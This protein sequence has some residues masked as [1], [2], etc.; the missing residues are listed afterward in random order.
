MSRGQDTFLS[1]IS[2]GRRTALIFLLV[3]GL[4]RGVGVFAAE[5]DSG[6]PGV[7]KYA[8]TYGENRAKAENTETARGQTGEKKKDQAVSVHREGRA[9]DSELRRRLQQR[10]RELKQL[11]DENRHLQERVTNV[12]FAP[13]II[14]PSPNETGKMTDDRRGNR[15]P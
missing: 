13:D 1:M 14:L 4:T 11:R 5:E 9:Q 15:K 7:L 10:E 12:K 8:Q 3:A 6:L 2:G